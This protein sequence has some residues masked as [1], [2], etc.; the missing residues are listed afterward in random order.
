MHHHTENESSLSSLFSLL[1]AL[2][3]CLVFFSFVP[4]SPSVVSLCLCL[5]P[6]GVVSCVVVFCVLC[7]T[8]KTTQCVH[9]K[10]PRVYVQNG[11]EA[12]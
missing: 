4:S 7:G 5:S 10:H 12:W 8:V 9:S 6:C 2:V 1:S 11:L 3:S